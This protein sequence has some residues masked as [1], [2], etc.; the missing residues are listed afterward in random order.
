MIL[1][2]T[3]KFSLH[4]FYFLGMDFT[5]LAC[6]LLFWHANNFFLGMHHSG[7]QNDFFGMKNVFSGYA[8]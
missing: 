6:I 3:Q 1:W 4:A 2:A 7:M 5:F 8:K